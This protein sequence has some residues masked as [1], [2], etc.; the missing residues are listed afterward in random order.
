MTALG[1]VPLAVLA[2]DAPVLPAGMLHYDVRSCEKA[3]VWGAFQRRCKPGESHVPGTGRALR[4]AGADTAHSLEGMV[5]TEDTQRPFP[6]IFGE[7][8]I[9]EAFPNAFLGVMIREAV[10]TRSPGRGDK[11][12]WLYEE[13]LGH[14]GADALRELV[15]W[16]RPAFWHD[17]HSTLQHD[18]RAALTCAMTAI[19]V[20]QGRYVA[21]GE[22]RGGYFFLPPWQLWQPW[23][24][25]CLDANRRD[26]RLVLGLDVWIDGVAFRSS[27]PLPL[28]RSTAALGSE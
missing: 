20:L 10:F 27:G 19:C 7:R 3:F 23:A 14:H 11:F 25:A 21:V 2:I 12:D 18:E 22:D 9:V 16:Q 26:S 4:R 24:R 8:N 6:R 15:A 17:V 28:V 5:C 1:D 13:W